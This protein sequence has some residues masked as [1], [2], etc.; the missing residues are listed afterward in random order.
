VA[1]GAS[2]GA[3]GDV[4]TSVDF[5]STWTHQTTGLPALAIFTSVASSSDGSH[6]IVAANNQGLYT[7]NDSGSTWT[8]Q[9]VGL[10]TFALWT[11][12]TSSSDGTRLVAVASKGGLFMST[13]SGSSWSEWSTSTA[14]TSVASS[15]DGLAVVAVGTGALYTYWHNMPNTVVA[16]KDS[17]L[18]LIY[19]GNGTFLIADMSGQIQIL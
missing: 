14:W 17:L 6:L 4:F 3:I 1:V 16:G 11:G 7:S 2:S 10:P 19:V 8:Q 9:T 18:D 12:L 5:G 15:S 13:D